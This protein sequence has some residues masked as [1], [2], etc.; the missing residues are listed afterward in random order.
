MEGESE[1]SQAGAVCEIVPGKPGER[2]RTA[3]HR[4]R[5]HA[6]G[7]GKDSRCTCRSRESSHGDCGSR[8]DG[9]S[10]CRSRERSRS[11]C[12]DP[13]CRIGQRCRRPWH[14]TGRDNSEI[15]DR[16][17]GHAG[18]A[19]EDCGGVSENPGYTGRGDH[20]VGRQDKH[21]GNDCLCASDALQDTED[22]GQL[23]QWSGASAHRLPASGGA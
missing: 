16:G 7:S 9:R 10:I 14:R 18:S 13:A 22:G 8:K 4:S 12:G 11:V 3:A 1:G 23:Q 19:P 17:Y 20:R 6:S 15:L 5:D 21:Q 2:N